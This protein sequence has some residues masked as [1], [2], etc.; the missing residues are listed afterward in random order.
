MLVHV[1]PKEQDLCETICS[2]NFAT[3][4]KNIHLGNEDTIV[5]KHC[6]VLRLCSLVCIFCITSI[7]PEKVQSN[8]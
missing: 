4:V 5:S 7:K 2:L 8:C 3:R 1:S 6:T